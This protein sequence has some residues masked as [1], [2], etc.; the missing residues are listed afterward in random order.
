MPWFSASDTA[1]V[2]NGLSVPVGSGT[3][4]SCQ[5]LPCV[6]EGGVEEEVFYKHRLDLMDGFPISGAEVGTR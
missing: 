1:G 6:Y 3:T 5:G 2:N 4:G